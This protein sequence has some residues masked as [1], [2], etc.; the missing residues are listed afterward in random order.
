[1][2][3]RREGELLVGALG[4]GIKYVAD[5]WGTRGGS[6]TGSGAERKEAAAEMLRVEALEHMAR[7]VL[8]R[9]SSYYLSAFARATTSR[10]C[11]YLA[12][13][14]SHSQLYRASEE[15]EGRGGEEGGRHRMIALLN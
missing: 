6:I 11:I 2:I 12:S 7:F 15:I 4:K 14:N 8:A 9:C 1:M 5:R 13:N 10:V 3:A